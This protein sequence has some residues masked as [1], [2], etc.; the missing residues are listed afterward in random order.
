MKPAIRVER[1]PAAQIELIYRVS[2]VVKVVFDA[3][4]DRV[5][6]E[7]PAEGWNT[8]SGTHLDR[9]DGGDAR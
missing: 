4:F 1:A 7:E 5:N 8:L 2:R 9:G 3:A 6:F